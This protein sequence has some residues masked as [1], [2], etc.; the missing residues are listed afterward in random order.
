VPGLV[1]LV[2]FVAGKEA[3]V[4]RCFA[5]TVWRVDVSDSVQ[6]VVKTP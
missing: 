2:I 3:S 5:A 1:R 6:K 4:P